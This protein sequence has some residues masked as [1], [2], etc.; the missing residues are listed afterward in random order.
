MTGTSGSLVDRMMG[1][2]RLD[3]A[4]YEEVERDND[5]T[6]QALIVVALASLANGIGALGD[7]GGTGLIGGIIYGIVGWLLFSLVAFFVGTRLLGASTTSAD[8]GQVMRALGFAYT[9]QI[10]NVIAFIPVIGWIVSAIAGIWFLIAAVIALRQSLELSTGRA[11]AVGIISII[12]YGIVQAIVGA[13]FGLG[14]WD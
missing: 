2:L 5:A 4:T 12:A 7:D 11:I 14:P 6:T 8:A 9:P 13:I 3:V 1:A 10:L